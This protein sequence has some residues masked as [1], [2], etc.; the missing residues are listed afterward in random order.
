MARMLHSYLG[1][2]VNLCHLFSEVKGDVMFKKF[3]GIVFYGI[4]SLGLE[5]PKKSGQ[6]S[7]RN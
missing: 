2:A 1:C 5:F 4:I 6:F 3:G 7:L